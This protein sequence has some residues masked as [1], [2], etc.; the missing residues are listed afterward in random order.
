VVIGLG[1]LASG[2]LREAV[3]ATNEIALE[4]R[5]ETQPSIS[6]KDDP[7]T[8]LTEAYRT[9]LEFDPK[10]VALYGLFFTLLLA[11]AFAPSYL[12]LRSAARELREH[13]LPLP[14]PTANDFDEVRQKRQT[15]DELLQTNLTAFGSFKAG[16][17]ILSPLAGSLTALILGLPT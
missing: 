14:P 12:A 5:P 7:T 9:A 3:L 8:A 15:L 2:L 4:K 1:T 10:Y 6:I 11:L 16:I 17:A 13:T